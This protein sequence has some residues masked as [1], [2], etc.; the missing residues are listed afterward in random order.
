MQEYPY[1]A[2][3]TLSLFLVRKLS[4]LGSDLSEQFWRTRNGTFEPGRIELVNGPPTRFQT[5]V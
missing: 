4:E 2:E 3:G 1:G 5:V